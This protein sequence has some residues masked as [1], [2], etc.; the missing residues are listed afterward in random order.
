[1]LIA[2]F[3]R[4]T[5]PVSPVFPTQHVFF[6]GRGSI[7]RQ[8]SNDDFGLANV[9]EVALYVIGACHSCIAIHQEKKR[10]FGHISQGVAGFG[11]SQVLMLFHQGAVGQLIDLTVF[12]YKQAGIVVHDNDFVLDGCRRALLDKVPDQLPAVVIAF[13]YQNRNHG[14]KLY[15]NIENL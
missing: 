9:V 11:R 2:Y 14:I 3:S 12:F 13:R 5:F 15:T 1:V 8:A 7:V 6:V 4:Y 10:V